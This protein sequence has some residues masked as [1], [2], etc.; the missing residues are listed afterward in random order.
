MLAQMWEAC[1]WS[2]LLVLVCQAGGTNM[3]A[4]IPYMDNAEYGDMLGD[5]KEKTHNDNYVVSLRKPENASV[6]DDGML[7][8]FLVS[9][10]EPKSPAVDFLKGIDIRT[11]AKRLSAHFVS[12]AK[13]ELGVDKLQVRTPEVLILKGDCLSL[14]N[15]TVY[16][17]IHVSKG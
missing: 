1:V 13:D 10:K 4:P 8:N 2:C 7:S 16:L 15:C 11:G 9:L 14:E 17:I 12:L 6:N 3:S 5:A